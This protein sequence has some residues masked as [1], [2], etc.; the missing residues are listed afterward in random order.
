ML[1]IPAPET[2]LKGYETGDWKWIFY[3]IAAGSCWAQ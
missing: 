2:Y 1:A 3:T